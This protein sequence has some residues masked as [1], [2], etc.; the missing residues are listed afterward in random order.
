M[1]KSFRILILAA[2]F[3]LAVIYVSLNPL[4]KFICKW[5]I[6]K[7]IPG[8]V[9]TI[10]G[11]NFDLFR[12]LTVSDIRVTKK[13]GSVILIR[14][15]A[16]RLNY[17]ALSRHL[18]F[19]PLELIDSCE[20]FVDSLEIGQVQLKS[21]YLK[22]SREDTD[23]GVISAKELKIGKLKIKDLLGKAWLKDEYLSVD[24]S[25]AKLLGGFFNCSGQ[26]RLTAPVK[27]QARLEFVTLDLGTFVKDFE[28]EEKAAV[29]GKVDGSLNLEGEAQGMD[30]LEGGFS[31]GKEGGMLTVKDRQFLERLAR[32]SRLDTDLVVESFQNYRYNTGMATASLKDDDI[33]FFVNLDGPNGKRNF[34]IISHDLN[35]RRKE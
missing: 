14:N 35:L 32:S 5:Q 21:G 23:N 13:P 7:L 27:Y 16:V 19:N 22:V 31:A 29:D 30:V 12:G 1:M 28:L 34:N 11:C 2:I 10:D 3:L 33:V 15:L 25:A 8:S 4:A 18:P 24:S 20:F 9:T 17:E 6:N 26:L